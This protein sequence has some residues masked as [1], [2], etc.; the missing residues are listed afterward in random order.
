[1]RELWDC[2]SFLLLG[3]VFPLSLSCSCSEYGWLVLLYG[4]GG[5]FVV[6]LIHLQGV[7]FVMFAFWFLCYCSGVFSCCSFR[8]TE[9]AEC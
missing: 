3:L 8:D 6:W 7:G 2:H 1:M 5:C 9:W 4:D